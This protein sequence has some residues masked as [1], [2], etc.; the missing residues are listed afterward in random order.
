MQTTSAAE[1]KKKPKKVSIGK[2][3]LIV[4]YLFVA[5]F[6]GLIGYLVYL[7]VYLREDYQNHPYNARTQTYEEQVTRGEIRSIDGQILAQTQIQ[8][9]GSEVRIYPFERLFAHVVGYKDNGGSGLESVAANTLL[10][11][12][13]N[14]VEQIQNELKNQKRKGDNL[15]TTF[16]AELQQVAYDALGTYQGAV[17]VMDVASGDLLVNVSKP[18]F[19]PNTIAQDWENLNAEGSNSPLLNRAMQGLYPPGSTFKIVTAL[20]YLR[21]FGTFDGFSYSCSGEFTS[22][23]YTIHCA[24]NHAHGEQ[25]FAQAFANSC[26]CAFASMSLELDKTSFASMADSLGFGKSWN[27]DLPSSKSK[28]SLNATTA[29]A[30][31][32]QTAIGQG[33]TIMTPLH[34]TMIIDAIAND[35]IAMTPNVIHSVENHTG[36][37][38]SVS[39]KKEYATFLSSE[40]A[41]RLKELMKGVVE[42]GTGGKLNDL[43]ISIGGKTGS[44]EHGDMT[45]NTHSW[46]VGFSDTGE[47]DIVVCVVAESAGSGSSVAV[48]IA[49]KIFSSY[50]D[51]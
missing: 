40:E 37:Q 50:F 32:M 15:I 2:E 38:V 49:K 26:N 51:L 18:D 7:N 33:D 3:Y 39:K 22:G 29:P 30:L 34:L 41:A 36:T 25:N 13:A 28:F 43:G 42:N 44:A 1:S 45:E 5:L 6:M 46:F 27:L 8:E 10:T 16:D 20:A 21:Q 4:S 23:N 31:T 14:A 19:D 11:S 24:G 12:H 17:L 35:G 48:P 47:R 9:D